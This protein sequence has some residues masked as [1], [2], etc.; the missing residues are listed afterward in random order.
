MWLR[1]SRER[2]AS[3]MRGIG[4]LPIRESFSLW[5]KPELDSPEAELRARASPD[6]LTAKLCSGNIIF[7]TGIDK[8]WCQAGRFTL[9][10]VDEEDDGESVG[11]DA[12]PGDEQAE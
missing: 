12:A 10:R 1:V 9:I 11:D 2:S 6:G 5:G 8:E 3:N 4:G 7:G